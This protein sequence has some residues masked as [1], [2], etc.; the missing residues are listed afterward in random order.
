MR[1]QVVCSEAWRNIRTGMTRVGLWG[2]VLMT[3]L[4]A[5]VELEASTVGALIARTREYVAKGGSTFVLLAESR[6]SSERCDRLASAASFAGAGALRKVAEVELPA[7]K[8]NPVPVYAASEGWWQSFGPGKG[9]AALAAPLAETVAP[10]V[11][12]GDAMRLGPITVDSRFP[13]PDD[14]R[15]ASVSRAIVTR[16]LRGPA[17][18]CWA[19]NADPAAGK[20]P[21]IRWSL[22]ADRDDGI[23]RLNTRVGE[24]TVADDFAHRPSRPA[25][26][27]AGAL[28]AALVALA[29]RRRAIELVLRRSL[30]IRRPALLLG[31][32]LE[33]LAWVLPAAVGSFCWGVIRGAGNPELAQVVAPIAAV[34]PCA[35]ALAVV[36]TVML[37]TRHDVDHFQRHASA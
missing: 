8:G 19:R 20:S 16:G 35:A 14:G 37:V 24:L 26:V 2:L 6:V 17:D 27:G 32:T 33:T 31:A 12:A 18:E 4:G 5:L 10:Q 13:W 11:F 30:G 3:L 23:A 15:L 22:D 25:W 9:Q 1:L 7:L 29:W 21:L 28:T 36:M 34:A